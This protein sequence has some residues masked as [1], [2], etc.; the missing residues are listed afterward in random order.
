VEGRTLVSSSQVAVVGGSAGRVRGGVVDFAV[1]SLEHLADD[2]G[3][4][5]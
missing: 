1:D 3:A 5:V 2:P 4:G